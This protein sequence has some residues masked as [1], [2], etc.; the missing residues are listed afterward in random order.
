M[1][2]IKQINVMLYF[3]GER[4]T[5]VRIAGI[6]HQDTDACDIVIS[7]HRYQENRTKYEV[8]PK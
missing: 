4:N 3:G 1:L 8:V 6:V 7:M 5:R 2:T